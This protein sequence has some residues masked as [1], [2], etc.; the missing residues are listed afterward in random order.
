MLHEN[1]GIHHV[2]LGEITVTAL[3]DGQFDADVA[4][5]IGIPAAEA[6]A[7]L[8]DSFR[9]LPPRIT[10]TC[11][12]LRTGGRHILVDIG[13]GALMGHVNG[14]AKRRLAALGIAPGSIDTVLITHA[15]SDHIGGL[16]NPDGGSAFPNAEV[17]ISAAETGYW[18]NHEVRAKALESGKSDFD[19]V[20]QILAPY[21]N[22]M[23]LIEDG[24]EVLPGI[25]AV[26]LPG[27]TPGHT[28]WRVASGGEALL[29]C[30]DIIHLPAIQF[31][32]PDV[33]M[34]FDNDVVLGCMTRARAM[35]M[36]ATERLLLA[37]MHLDFP[38]FGH[39]RRAGAGYAFEPLVWAPTE[40]G[41]FAAS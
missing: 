14:A 17:V 18:L 35:E 8:R 27:H 33:G 4:W 31:G 21:S 15:H 22:R 6:E 24:Q 9:V 32:R 26:H 19:L 29:I 12:L 41:L 13:A 30:G 39:V 37:G 25:A 5:L 40:S 3:N 1:P 20:Q 36:A 34:V 23:R 11:F 10:V 38:T 2:K 16:V 28:G 7:L